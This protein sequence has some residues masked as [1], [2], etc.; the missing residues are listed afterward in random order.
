MAATD[1]SFSPDGRQLAFRERGPTGMVYPGFATPVVRMLD[2]SSEY[3]SPTWLTIRDEMHWSPDGSWLLFPHDEAGS[4][5]GAGPAWSFWKFQPD[6]CQFSRVAQAGGPGQVRV[7]GLIGNK[8]VYMRI[9]SWDPTE[10]VI[11]ST[12]ISTGE[13]S[14]LYRVKGSTIQDASVSPD[15]RQVA[16]FLRGD[17]AREGLYI[18]TPPDPAP[19]RLVSGSVRGSRARIMWFPGEHAILWAGIL[20]GEKGVWRIPLDGSELQKL[21]FDATGVNEVR[22]SLDARRIV[23]TKRSSLSNEVWAFE[24]NTTALR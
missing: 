16:F 4:G 12:D 6:S 15:G 14:H 19:T 21:K 7:A 1:A 13:I 3:H 5:E 8:I 9:I 23:Y 24:Q 18:I 20:K 17:R 22:V 11:E 10:S 2:G